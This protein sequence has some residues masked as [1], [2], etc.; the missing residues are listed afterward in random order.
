MISSRW[1]ESGLIHLPLFR[2]RHWGQIP[3]TPD[4][5]KIGGATLDSGVYEDVLRS[6]RPMFEKGAP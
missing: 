5:T 4:P 2:G 1:R 6:E 3:I